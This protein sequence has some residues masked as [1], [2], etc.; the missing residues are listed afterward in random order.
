M[1]SSEVKWVPARFFLFLGTDENPAEP[2]LENMVD[3]QSVQSRSRELLPWQQLTC[4]GAFVL[5]EQHPF[6]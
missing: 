1:A 5:V 2:D 3:D 4:E 6:S